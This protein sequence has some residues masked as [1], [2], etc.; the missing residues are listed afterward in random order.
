MVGLSSSYRWGSCLH[1]EGLRRINTKLAAKELA[2]MR[3][4]IPDICD[5]TKLIQVSFSVAPYDLLCWSSHFI[6]HHLDSPFVQLLVSRPSNIT[7]PAPVLIHDISLR[8]EGNHV[9]YVPR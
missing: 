5:G 1:A 4:L 9:R 6:G 7:S 3:D 2:P 8:Y